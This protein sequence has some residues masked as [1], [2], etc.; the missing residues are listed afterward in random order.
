ML[1][2][3]CIGIIQINAVLLLP[4]CRIYVYLFVL[5]IFVRI[6]ST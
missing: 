4:N 2:N 5:V 6:L 1:F 3:E